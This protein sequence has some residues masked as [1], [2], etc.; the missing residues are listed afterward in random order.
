M[1]LLYCTVEPRNS[2]WQN[3]VKPHIT[4]HFSMTNFESCFW[5]TKGACA[6]TRIYCFSTCGV[7]IFLFFLYSD[8]LNALE[9]WKILSEKVLNSN[10]NHFNQKV[11]LT[12]PPSLEMND[13]VWY[14]L[15]DVAKALDRMIWASEELATEPGFR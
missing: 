2:V 10:V 14:P 8:N 13:F 7:T 1:E 11:L 5:V 3:S 4:E 12:K 9:A 15:I 6:I